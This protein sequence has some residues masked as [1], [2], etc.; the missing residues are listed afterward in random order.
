LQGLEIRSYCEIP[1]DK[2]KQKFFFVI[3]KT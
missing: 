3:K 2:I 1:L